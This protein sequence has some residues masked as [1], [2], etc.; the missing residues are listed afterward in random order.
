MGNKRT[1]DAENFMATL[2]VNYDSPKL[3]DTAFRDM[4]KNT[5]NSVIYL[6]EHKEEIIKPCFICSRIKVLTPINMPDRSDIN[7]CTDCNMRLMSD[8]VNLKHVITDWRQKGQ[9]EER[10]RLHDEI[11]VASVEFSNEAGEISA[12]GDIRDVY[13]KFLKKLK[14]IVS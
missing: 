10:K 2:A 4:F 14:S 6:P 3:S 5:I 11:E 7:I 8:I 13:Y 1:I 9:Y 12:T